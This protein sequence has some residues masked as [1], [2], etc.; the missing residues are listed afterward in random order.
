MDLAAFLTACAAFVVTIESLH[1]HS[2][3]LLFW[4]RFLAVA[5]VLLGL[6]QLAG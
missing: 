1:R 3:G 2:R 6:A 4:G 5:A